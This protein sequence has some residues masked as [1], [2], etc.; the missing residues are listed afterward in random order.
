MSNTELNERAR[1]LFELSGNHSMSSQERRALERDSNTRSAMSAL[2]RAGE[3]LLA[4]PDSTVAMDFFNRAVAACSTIG[5]NI[6]IILSNH[7][8]L[9]EHNEQSIRT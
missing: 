9:E 6:D 8:K 3:V 5:V 1:R 7:Q 2:R 4:H